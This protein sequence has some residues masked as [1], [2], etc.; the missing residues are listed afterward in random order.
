MNVETANRLQMLRKKNGYSQEELAE[1]IGISRQ[2]VSKWER[3][4]ASPDTDNLILLARLYGIT[5]DEL[6]K[7]DS[8]PMPDNEGISLH[9][10][11]YFQSE[12]APNIADDSEIY[13]NGQPNFTDS[14]I[15]EQEERISSDREEPISANRAAN[16]A[17]VGS[18]WEKFRG[19]CKNIK[20]GM[21]EYRHN[22]NAAD[23]D[24]AKKEKNFANG[25]GNQA[26][27]SKSNV[28]QP[29]TLLDKLF[30][31]I[32]TFLFFCSIVQNHHFVCISWLIF[33][34]IPIYYALV[35]NRRGYKSGKYD[36]FTAAVKFLNIAVPIGCVFM[37]LFFTIAYSGRYSYLIWTIFF[38]IP[39]Y[40][41]G[42]A[43]IKKRNL[44]IFCYPA[45]VLW[46]GMLMIL[47]HHSS[48]APIFL[49][50]LSTIPF[51]YVIVDHFQKKSK[52]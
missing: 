3:A 12:Q 43:A 50:L 35:H 27:T 28:K 32:I 30:P 24:F 7:T 16:S 49:L 52:K 5:L 20:S 26:Q 11:D 10:E 13:P 25:S 44:M 39:I 2:A 1:K 45:V 18:I 51:Y 21:E 37:F 42:T 40:Y 6:L 29:A 23:S 15:Y 41:T 46:I 14:P 33:F 9:K 38:I 17:L 48:R 34:A 8:I 31:L 47:S 19:F 4:E 36:L 22:E